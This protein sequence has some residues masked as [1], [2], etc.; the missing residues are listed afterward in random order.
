MADPLI[1][2][3][4]P[5]LNREQFIGATLDS[6]RAQTHPGWECIVVDD[7]STDGTLDVVRQHADQD[8][9]IKCFP[10]DRP[11]PSASTCRNVGWRRCS[12]DWIMF[13]DS[14]D[15]LTDTCV[16]G[17]IN[18][19][20]RAPDFDFDVFPGEFFRHA[21]G[22]R[23]LRNKR[24]DGPQDTY[25]DMFLR[26]DAPWQTTAPLWKRAALDILGG[27]SEKY[28]RR[29]DVE[30]HVR[31][32]IRGLDFKVHDRLAPDHF[33]RLA[34]KDGLKADPIRFGQMAIESENA[35]IGESYSALRNARMTRCEFDRHS[36]SL[37]S[38]MRRLL[39]QT[40]WHDLARTPLRRILKCVWTGA[41]T[42]LIGRGALCSYSL[43]VA[44]FKL[45]QARQTRAASRGLSGRD[46][47]P[48][49]R[50][51]KPYQCR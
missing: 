16:A 41:A 25:L 17:R 11:P 50:G 2:I 18:A 20:R 12:S 35:L 15:L 44:R 48:A 9:R 6:V 3:V 30:L 33:V 38:R 29:Q 40:I 45:G 36:A 47:A 32:L 42:G 10:R 31:A 28:Q 24:L 23:R 46:P 5:V 4:V 21:V 14:D 7:G 34:V 37:A 49:E 27:F 26:G 39:E 1:S 43:K 22:D 8:S 13:L 19:V 51:R